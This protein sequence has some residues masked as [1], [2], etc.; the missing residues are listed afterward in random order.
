MIPDTRRLLRFLTLSLAGPMAASAQGA[1]PPAARTAAAISVADLRS[2]LFRI[3]D[4]SMMGRETGSRGAFQTAK[5][6][7]DEFQ[8]LGLQPAG[9]SGGWFQA[10]PFFIPTADPATG[11]V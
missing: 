7:A 6:V 11:P 8:R 5:Y 10:V 9:E 1:S 4:D 3:A 2:R